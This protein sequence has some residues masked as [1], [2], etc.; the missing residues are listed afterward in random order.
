LFN[1]TKKKKKYIWEEGTEAA[2]QE[3]ENRLI[4]A[5]ILAF[6]QADGSEF[7]VDTDASAYAIGA[8]LSQVQDGRERVIAYGSRCLDK[9]E[10]NYCVTRREMLAV[11]Y[12]TKYFKHY[13]L[14]R[15]F[16]LRT[17]YESLSW[18]QNFR[19]PDGQVHKWIQQLS[20]FHMKIEHRPGARHGN[21]DAMFR[22]VT[23]DGIMCMQCSMPWEC[24]HDGTTETEI[25]SMKEGGSSD[26]V[27]YISDESG[28][29]VE[30]L[31]DQDKLSNFNEPESDHSGE[32]P[33][34]KR[35]RKRNRP[36]PAK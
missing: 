35:G 7:I 32:S 11:V 22:L 8:V 4:S 21:A 33:V 3:L 15:R 26:S 6:P 17:D 1:L 36:Q 18:L 29:D 14:G 28:D 30:E 10:R 27:E 25:K 9:P 34:L 23:P 19:D 20:Q 2:F 12:F 13:L 31:G 5:P 16:L 24:K